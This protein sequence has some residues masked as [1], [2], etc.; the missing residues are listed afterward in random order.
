M[1]CLGFEPGAAGYLAL[2]I[3]LSYGGRPSVNTFFCVEKEGRG[4]DRGSEKEK[5]E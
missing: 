4:I 5:N 3:P 1:L 2:T